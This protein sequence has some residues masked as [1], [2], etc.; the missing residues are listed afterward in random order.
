MLEHFLKFKVEF[1]VLFKLPVVLYAV[2]NLCHVGLAFRHKPLGKLLY[3]A[4][5]HVGEDIG[6]HASSGFP[7]VGKGLNTFSSCSWKCRLSALGAEA[8]KSAPEKWEERK[9]HANT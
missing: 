4:S 6:P 8:K 5:F 9:K 3:D 7:V 1:G 2:L